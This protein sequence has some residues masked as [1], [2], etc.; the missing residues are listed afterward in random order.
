VVRVAVA[1]RFA[2]L[3]AVAGLFAV[4]VYRLAQPDRGAALT[5][6]VQTHRA[7]AVPDVSFR[8]LWRDA[9]TWPE[10]LRSLAQRGTLS[11]ADL[12]GYPVV[13]NF[14]S[15]WCDACKREASLLAAAAAARRGDVVFLG[16]DVNDHSGD[17]KRFL[18][19][20]R[21]PYVAVQS[22][23]AAI[24]RFGLIGL[25]ETFYVDRSGRIQNVTRGQLSAPTLERE[26]GSTRRAPALPP[27]RA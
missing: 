13:V 2:A 15:S 14:W 6:A 21:V 23:S 11:I 16:V 9:S 17:A 22:G 1:L 27:A 8:V 7:P 19:R 25:P 12:R 26:L 24:E 20:H 4:L 18:G 5:K 10:G 3:V